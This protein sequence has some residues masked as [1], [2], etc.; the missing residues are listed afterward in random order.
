[1]KRS[2]SPVI[3]VCLLTIACAVQQASRIAVWEKNQ[4]QYSIQAKAET[5]A[6]ATDIVLYVRVSTNASSRAL[7][8]RM[9]WAS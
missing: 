4:Q 3:V 7:L 8:V 9:I 6:I 2:I 1:M 5:G